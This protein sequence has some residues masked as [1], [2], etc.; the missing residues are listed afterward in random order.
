MKES[1]KGHISSLLK[2][3]VIRPSQSQHRTTAIIVYSGT[4]QDPK[5]G[6]VKK[7]KERMVFNY[8]RLNDN[9]E[10]DQYSLPVFQRKMDNCFKGTEDFIAVYIDDILV[11]SESE[12]AHAKHLRILL[13]KCRRNGLIL[14]PTKMTIGQRQTEF[15]GAI[16]GNGEIRLQPNIIKK[17]TP[18]TSVWQ[19][20]PYQQDWTLVKQIKEQVQ[21]LPALTI[22]PTKCFIILETDGC[23]EGW[24]GI[25]KWRPQKY[26]SRSME[27]PCAYASGKFNPP[28]STIDAE[29]FAVMNS[30]ESLKIYYLE[31]K[32]IL[33]RTDCQ[34]II[35]F[36]NKSNINKPSRVRW[37]ADTCL[38]LAPSRTAEGLAESSRVEPTSGMS[39]SWARRLSPDRLMSLLSG[40]VSLGKESR[41]QQAAAWRPAKHGRKPKE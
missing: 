3:G 22:P 37:I 29:I 39:S 27:K 41:E 12:D 31:Q 5:T 34:A 23:M 13:E 11:F 19:D 15:L 7:G 4:T 2:V 10:K 14:S 20:K 25:C 38:I 6:E 8:K 9:T 28:K 30:L 26:D 16:I 24:G 40:E 17:I 32:E 18:G 21:N 1:F 36:F 33:I 35:S